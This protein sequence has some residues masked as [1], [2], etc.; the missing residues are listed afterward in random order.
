MGASFVDAPPQQVDAQ[1][2]FASQAAAHRLPDPGEILA[3][4]LRRKR[5]RLDGLVRH[6]GPTTRPS[7]FWLIAA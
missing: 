2:R 5:S 3:K 7:H 6:H 4:F 1:D